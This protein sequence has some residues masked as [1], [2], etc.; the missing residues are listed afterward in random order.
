MVSVEKAL[1]NPEAV[2]KK[3]QE[4]VKRNDLSREQKIEILRRWE[5]DV[6]ELQVADD[7][8]MTAKEPQVTAVTLDAV[9]N[10]LRSLGAPADVEHSAPTKQGGS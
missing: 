3:P 4:V 10:A 5:Y 2:F 7:E 9:L 1:L 8:S 6:R